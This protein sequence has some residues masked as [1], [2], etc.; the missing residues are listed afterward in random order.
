RARGERLARPLAPV[1]ER[2]PAER[3]VVAVLVDEPAHDPE[4]EQLAERVD[5]RSVTDLELRFAKWR[6]HFVLR[7]LHARSPAD[8]LVAVLH[9]ADAADVEAHRGVELER[10]AARRGLRVAE[11]DADLLPQL[12]DEDDDRAG[13]VRDRRELSER[14][15]HE[16]RLQA[17]V[18]IAHFAL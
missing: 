18:L 11:D 10:V 16:P 3:V 8:D 5:A 15:A 17:H 2:R 14:L 12:V 9:L 7:D 4:I 13:S 1:A 6:R